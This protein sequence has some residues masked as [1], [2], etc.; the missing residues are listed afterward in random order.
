[1]IRE[2][3]LEWEIRKLKSERP[4]EAFGISGRVIPGRGTSW[5]RE[6]KTEPLAVGLRKNWKVDRYQ[7]GRA[8]ES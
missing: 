2:G 5:S 4:A 1:M 7:T 8:L 6:P 3:F